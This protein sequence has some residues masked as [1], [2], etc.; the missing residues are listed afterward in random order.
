MPAGMATKV[1]WSG[2][3]L[4]WVI[5]LSPLPRSKGTPPNVT[6]PSG[7]LRYPSWILELAICLMERGMNA[8]LTTIGVR[9]RGVGEDVKVGRTGVFVGDGVWVGGAVGVAVDV[10]VGVADGGGGV[11]VGAGVGV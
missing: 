3:G 7:G 10:S 9:E 11:F 1:G 2:R 4:A 8:N 6:W 5:T